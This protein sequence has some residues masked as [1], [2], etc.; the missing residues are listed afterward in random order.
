M[1]EFTS[2]LTAQQ[3]SLNE[4][5]SKIDSMG[6]RR[7]SNLTQEKLIEESVRHHNGLYKVIDI[8]L[9]TAQS[10]PKQ[11]DFRGG[12]IAFEFY[13]SDGTR[14]LTA[15][16]SVKFNGSQNDAISFGYGDYLVHPFHQLFVSW[17]AQSGVTARLIIGYEFD[18][19]FRLQ[20]NTNA[21][22]ATIST[23]SAITG[24]TAIPSG[25]S[26]VSAKGYSIAGGAALTTLYT[27][28]AG[29]TLHITNTHQGSFPQSYQ[30]E[31]ALIVTD[32]S[33]VLQYV[34]SNQFSYS[35]GAPQT[36]ANQAYLPHIEVPA[37]YKIK[38][39]KRRLDTDADST[40][41]YCYASFKG[42]EI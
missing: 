24:L 41:P 37:G 17:S 32:A 22:I 39:R 4:L 26:P 8:L 7:L 19:I 23:V 15:S 21:N 29:K 14:N 12:V 1:N 3:K 31:N 40:D 11:Y 30:T 2:L 42:Y 20:R 34:I 18:N 25:A 16:V 6:I 27:V 33:D 5:H 35:S 38:L 9:T 10:Q 36:N 28:T 13:N